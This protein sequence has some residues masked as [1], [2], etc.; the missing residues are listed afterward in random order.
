[1]AEVAASVKA[2]PSTRRVLARP[3]KF[4]S[5]TGSLWLYRTSYC[6]SVAND[7]KIAKKHRFWTG[8]G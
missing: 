3:L 7:T 5:P 8:T 6:N 4:C 2:L 1:V